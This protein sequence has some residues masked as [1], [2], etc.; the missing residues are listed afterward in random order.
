MSVTF[1]G[2]LS[3]G[4]IIDGRFPLL[5]ELGG[6]EWTSAWLTELDDG[7]TQEAAI[8]IFPF[9]SVDSG[10]TI[11]RW[12]V[13]RTLSHPHLM[14]LFYAGRCEVD[15]EDLLYVVT[16]YADEILS[17]VLPER[18][19]S[20]QEAREMLSS[21]LAAL[22]YLH[23]RCLMHGHLMPTNIM[24]IDG[25]LKLSPDFG[26]CS[27]TRSVYDPPEAGTG[28]VGPAADIWSLGILLVEALTQ[29]P[30]VWDRSQGV[31]PEIPAT[32]PEPFFTICRECLRTD[33]E[34]RCT[35]AGIK[36]L[37]NPPQTAEAVVDL[38]EKPSDKFPAILLVGAV[39]GLLFLIAAFK[40]GWDLTPSSPWP[41]PQPTIKGPTAGLAP[42]AATAPAWSP[43]PTADPA[44]APASAAEPSKGA[45]V[46]GSAP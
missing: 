7:R 33:P 8:K 36:A 38:T 12:D 37:L 23:Q 28:N 34:R 43:A 29:E 20:P 9:Q 18:P 32:I 4:R 13:A 21:I 10:T 35:L 17:Q 41:G 15:G 11:A 1:P 5:H 14:P 24:V 42:T 46:K 6:T 27:R 2:A 30:P 39:L 16:E 40:F 31:E 22:S 44:P 25:Q 45:A 26:W 19:L 3:V